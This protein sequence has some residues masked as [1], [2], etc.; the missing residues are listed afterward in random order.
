VFYNAF[1]L[2]YLVSP[3]S[4]HRFVGFLEEKAVVT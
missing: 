3:K 2:G 1:F 4:A